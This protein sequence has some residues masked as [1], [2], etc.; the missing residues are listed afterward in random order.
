MNVQNLKDGQKVKTLDDLYYIDLCGEHNSYS[1]DDC[2]TQLTGKLLKEMVKI[3]SAGD[4]GIYNK[5]FNAL[6]F[7]Q[8]TEEDPLHEEEYIFCDYSDHDEELDLFKIV[9]E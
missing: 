3:A 1:T 4:I 5:E 6:K 2:Y 9:E 7:K 8:P